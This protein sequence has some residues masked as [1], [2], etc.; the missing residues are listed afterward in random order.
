MPTSLL[1]TGTSKEALKVR[2]LNRVPCI[3]Y[4][5][6]FCKDKG[7]DVLALLNPG[8]EV[9]VMTV[10]YTAYLGLKVRV[11]N[12]GAQKIDRFSLAIC[13]MVIAAFQIVNKFGCSRFFQKTFL[14]VDISM[15]V[16]LSM[17]FLTFSNANIQFA[18]KEP[19][20]KTYTTKKALPITRRVKIINWKKFAK[21]ALD[22]NFEA[23]IVYVS[24]LGS[25]ITIH[26]ARE[27]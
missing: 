11:T 26:P 5:V 17:L 16:I 25:R 6:Q 14:L 24:F 27:A 3:C 22:K 13:G 15:Q 23:F 2:V 12:V 1:V 21:A 20:W 9:N 7:K 18:V 8:N 19:T 10:A 4:F